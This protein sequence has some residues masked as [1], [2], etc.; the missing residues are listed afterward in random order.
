LANAYTASLGNEPSTLQCNVS[1]IWHQ[2]F[3]IRIIHTEVT[4][5]KIKTNLYQNERTF[6]SY[7][8]T[9]VTSRMFLSVHTVDVPLIYFVRIHALRLNTDTTVVSGK[10]TECK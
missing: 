5:L 3:K 10:R 1:I 7:V 4:S 2:K 6:Y 8:H 9:A